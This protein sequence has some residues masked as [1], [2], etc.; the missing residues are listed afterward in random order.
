MLFNWSKTI[1]RTHIQEPSSAAALELLVKHTFTPNTTVVEGKQSVAIECK[2]FT[3]IQT[4][5]SF[6]SQSLH[7]QSQ[8]KIR[9]SKGNEQTGALV[10][11][12]RRK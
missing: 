1:Q 6:S 7:M 9:K 11:Q 4:A 2:A 10:Q 5:Y 12:Y 3:F 8:I